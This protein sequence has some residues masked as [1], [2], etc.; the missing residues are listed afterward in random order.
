METMRYLKF[1][2][3]HL[4][5]LVWPS[6][7][8]DCVGQPAPVSQTSPKNN[9][10]ITASLFSSLYFSPPFSLL[11]LTM[12]RSGQ[13]CA[14]EEDVMDKSSEEG[15]KERV[16][17]KRLSLSSILSRAREREL[18]GKRK[19]KIEKETKGRR[20]RSEGENWKESEEEEEE[21]RSKRNKN[22]DVVRERDEEM[23]KTR[24]KRDFSLSRQDDR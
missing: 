15:K 19:G 16:S 13:T 18:E 7:S 11:Y 1:N 23:R 24:A 9:N 5:A 4:W 10:P 6:L 3:E 12:A 22:K 8:Y 14:G 2:L 21:D 20:E 17:E